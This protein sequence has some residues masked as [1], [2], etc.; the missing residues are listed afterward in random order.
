MFQPENFRWGCNDRV[1]N[2][3]SEDEKPY[4]KVYLDAFYIEKFE[5]TQGEYSECVRAGKRKGGCQDNF[6]YNGFT[7]ERQPVVGV[8]LGAGQNLLR[9]G[10]EAAAHRGAMGKGG[11]GDRRAEVSVG[12]SI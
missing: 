11:A 7:D 4:H 10:R 5:V 3:C 12:E 1:D 2:E 8:D 9:M 6:K